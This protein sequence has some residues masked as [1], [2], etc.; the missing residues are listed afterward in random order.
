MF[1][2]NAHLALAFRQVDRT[3]FSY[4]ATNN[5][6]TSPITFKGG[7][8]QAPQLKGHGLFPLPEMLQ[9]YSG[10]QKPINQLK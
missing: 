5:I 6:I 9:Q 8:L 4:L 7:Y 1:E 2:I 3:E 10:D